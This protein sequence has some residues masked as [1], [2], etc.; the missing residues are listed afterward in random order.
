M[1][2]KLFSIALIL[3]CLSLLA[4][5]TYTYHRSSDKA[6]QNTFTMGSV[7]VAPQQY[8]LRGNAQVPVTD[9]VL[10]VMPDA[11]ISRVVTVKCMKE[12]AWVR[13]KYVLS[14]VD[15][16]G[17]P[18]SIKPERMEKMIRIDA[19][20]DH[21][22]YRDGWWYY[23]SPL[24]S[25][26]STLPLFEQIT[27]YGPYITNEFQNA[28]VTMDFVAQAVQLANNGDGKDVFTAAGW[29]EA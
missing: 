13:M 23:Q 16:K 11:T 19:D 21:W 29:P 3:I 2:K 18:I 6:S 15:A 27:F 24:D 26:E 8:E 4:G 5:K 1:K 28:T 12:P 14:A 17:N 22:T 9:G 7:E 10:P 20:T 25:R